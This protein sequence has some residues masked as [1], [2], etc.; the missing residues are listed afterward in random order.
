MRENDGRKI[1]HKTLETL[2]IRAVAQVRAG[3]HPEEVAEVLGMARSTVYGW[4]AREASGGREALLA[5]PIPGRPAKLGWEQAQDI[6]AVVV[7]HTPNQMALDF[8]LWTRDLVR[9][10]ILTRWGVELSVTAVGRLLRRLGLSPQRPVYRAY[11]ADPVKVKAWQEEGYPALA[12]AA[13]KRG[14][15]VYFGDEASV[16]SDYH[17]GTTW[18]V[19]GRTPVINQATGSRHSVNMVSAITAKGQ[20]YFQIIDGTMTADKFVD[21]CTRLLADSGRPVILVVD[22]HSVHRSRIVRDWVES[23]N[24]EFTLAFLPAYSPQLNPDEW[25]WKNVKHDQ[26]GKRLTRGKEQFTAFCVNGLQRLR[27]LPHLVAGFFADPHLGYIRTA[28]TT[29]AQLT[30]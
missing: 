1:D 15:V 27:D 5:K 23:T 19:R 2:R 25:V 9:Q 11:Q 13:K 17:A 4:L 10:L 18:A 8:G 24:G 7:G 22:N 6:F 16:R 29:A 3:V 28:D 12:A 20:L 26:V 21:F 30:V 14:A